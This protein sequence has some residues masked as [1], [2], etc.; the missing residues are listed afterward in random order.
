M[1]TDPATLHAWMAIALSAAAGVLFG[2]LARAGASPPPVRFLAIGPAIAA[3]AVAGAYWLEVRGHPVWAFALAALPAGSLTAAAK[4]WM[5]KREVHRAARFGAWGAVLAALAVAGVLA[6]KREG[7]LLE[8]QDARRRQEASFRE[9]LGRARHAWTADP[10]RG[11]AEGTSGRLSVWL[12]AAPRI[13]IDSEYERSLDEAQAAREVPLRVVLLDDAFAPLEPGAEAGVTVT[14]WSLTVRSG[15]EA[16]RSFDFGDREARPLL[17][18]QRKDFE[19]VWDGRDSAGELVPPGAYA[20][21]LSVR[22]ED[23]ALS[24]E[25]PFEI[26][27]AG[28]VETVEVDAT[29]QYIEEQQRLL[30]WQR[31]TDEALRN[32]ERMRNFPPPF[33]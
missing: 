33:H 16:L 20:W 26:A 12:A 1:M 2:A 14:A 17:P 19:V 15:E 8:E 23:G 29:R 3:A 11:V 21:S 28:P 22:T 18:S 24:V 9:E 32:L 27:D 7:A 4:A 13:E 25:L 10:A 30:Q 5:V 6:A 31:T